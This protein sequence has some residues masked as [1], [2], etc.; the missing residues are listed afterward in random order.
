MKNLLLTLLT[1]SFFLIS[2][3]ASKESS[4]KVSA[5][6][7][8]PC[9]TVANDSSE[10]LRMYGSDTSLNL[11]SAISGAR[12][13]AFNKVGYRITDATKKAL[14]GISDIQDSVRLKGLE[15]VRNGIIIP[16]YKILKSNIYK[17]PNGMY[18]ASV[19]IETTIKKGDI[20]EDIILQL[21][22]NGCIIGN[23]ELFKDIF[24]KKL[25]ED[26][27]FEKHFK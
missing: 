5:N 19:C 26:E 7:V 20:C 12:R 27:E 25:F 1:A 9:E 23:V 6:Y 15:Y 24:I 22:K 2:C 8:D 21:E 10:Y 16:S 14:Q 3:K 17:Q 11:Q 4:T 18:R 13:H